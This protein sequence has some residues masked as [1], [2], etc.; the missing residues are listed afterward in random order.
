MKKY[1]ARIVLCTVALALIAGFIYMNF[2]HFQRILPIDVV[3]GGIAL[4]IFILWCVA[5]SGWMGF[6]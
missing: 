1:F 3:F 2:T 4:Y 6:D 5:E